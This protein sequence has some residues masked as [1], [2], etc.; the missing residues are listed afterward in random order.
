M[1]AKTL[2]LLQRKEEIGRQMLAQ[3]TEGFFDLFNRFMDYQ[4]WEGPGVPTSFE[5]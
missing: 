3:G 4:D 2:L 1:K 5:A